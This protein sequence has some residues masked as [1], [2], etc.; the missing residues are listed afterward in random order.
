M[1]IDA[2]LLLA[3]C[4]AAFVYEDLFVPDLFRAGRGECYGGEGGEGDGGEEGSL[5]V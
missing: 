5:H 3:R 4:E 2:R 1:L